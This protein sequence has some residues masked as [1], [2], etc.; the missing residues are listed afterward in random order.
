ML[1]V[2]HKAHFQALKGISGI[3]FCIIV[4]FGDNTQQYVLETL[5]KGRW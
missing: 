4:S 5:T 2:W 3:T 1:L